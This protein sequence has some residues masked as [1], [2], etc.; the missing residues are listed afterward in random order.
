MTSRF[1]RLQ[2]LLVDQRVLANA[3][4]K[5]G[6]TPLHF[7]AYRKTFDICEAL[8]GDSRVEPCHADNFGETPLAL[9]RRAFSL[10]EPD[11]ELRGP[12]GFA[13]DSQAMRSHTRNSVHIW[14][15]GGKAGESDSA[16]KCNLLEDFECLWNRPSI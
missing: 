11:S 9:L 2:R 5:H 8:L 4:D 12:E 7:A 6:R 3:S 14:D 10:C 13:F 16:V 15:T 1:F